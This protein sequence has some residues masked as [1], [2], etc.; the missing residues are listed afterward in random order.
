MNKVTLMYGLPGSGKSFLAK[1][2]YDKTIKSGKTS[3]ILSTDDFF[4]VDGEYKWSGEFIG[5]AHKWNQGRF[6]LELFKGTN[7]IIIDNTGLGA[8]QHYPYVGESINHGYEWELVQSKTK[9]ANDPAECSKKN[10]HGL[11]E[12]MIKRMLDKSESYAKIL[13]ELQNKFPQKD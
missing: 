8:W 2:L 12:E 13:K 1:K 9:W 5:L 10:S 7:H 6:Y 4:M 11:T 3:V